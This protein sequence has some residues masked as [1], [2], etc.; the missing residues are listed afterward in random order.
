M[1][2]KRTIITSAVLGVSVFSFGQRPTGEGSAAR[3]GGE[4]RPAATIASITQN[5]KKME[6]FYTFY[7]DEK[8]G[9]IYL[10]IDRFNQEFCHLDG[11]H[12]FVLP[13]AWLC[14]FG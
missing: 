7:Y 9:K 4:A 5:A 1:T 12:A 2:I 6:G 10:E 14:R 3:G 13:V 11:D 8:A